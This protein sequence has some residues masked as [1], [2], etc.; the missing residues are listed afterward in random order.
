[1]PFIIGDDRKAEY[2]ECLNRA[3][4]NGDYGSLTG[5]FRQEQEKYTAMVKDFICPVVK[6]EEAFSEKERME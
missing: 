5:F 6:T 4:Q 1:M 2:Y 3:Q